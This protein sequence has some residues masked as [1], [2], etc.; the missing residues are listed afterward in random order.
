MDEWLIDGEGATGATNCCPY[1]AGEITHLGRRCTSRRGP[2]FP[3]MN[4]P[5]RS[6]NAPLYVIGDIHGRLDLLDRLIEAIYRDAGGRGTDSLTVTVGD[7]ID[8]GPD[9]RGVIER[10]MANPFPGRY[11]ALKG[12]HEAIME[13]FL[14]DPQRRRPLAASRGPGNPALVR[15]AGVEVLGPAELRARRRAATRRAH[16]GRDAV[17]RIVAA[18]FSASAATS[19][20]TPAC[21]R[22]CRSISRASRTC[23]GSAMSF[24]TATWISARSSCTDTRRCPNRRCGPT[25]SMSIPAPFISGR[26]TCVVL[27]NGSHR[28][29]T[30]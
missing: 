10:L 8:R 14:A 17:S 2:D 4:A 21:G 3:I 30:A 16:A 23:S 25:A 6:E 5:D 22:A 15:R 26:L 11:V 7:Y 20:A 24:S 13:S 19:F 1:S 27:E 9:S 18:V 12:N 28:F 29:L